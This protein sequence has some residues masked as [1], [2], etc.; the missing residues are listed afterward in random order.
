[1][2]PIA[3]ARRVARML[4]GIGRGLQATGLVMRRHEVNGQPGAVVL[5]PDG[6]VVSVLAIDIADGAVQTVRSVIN[7]DKLHHLGPVADVWAL[8]RRRSGALTLRAEDTW[9]CSPQRTH[10]S[11]L[12]GPAS[13]PTRS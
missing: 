5:D 11:G 12:P 10:A 6:R 8:M 4:V 13:R 7:P 9:H 1:M 3:G 2:H